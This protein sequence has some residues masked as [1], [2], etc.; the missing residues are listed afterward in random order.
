MLLSLHAEPLMKAILKIPYNSFS[1][2]INEKLQATEELNERAKNDISSNYQKEI[3][4]Q[5]KEIES[6][7]TQYANQMEQLAKLHEERASLA[8]TQIEQLKMELAKAQ[9]SSAINWAFVIAAIILGLLIGR[10]CN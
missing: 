4:L 2:G 10:S 6:L 5:K 3:E 8:K 1:F 7:N 9:S